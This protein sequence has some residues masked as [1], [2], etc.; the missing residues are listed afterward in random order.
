MKQG[1]VL[2]SLDIVLIAIKLDPT[3]QPVLK[4]KQFQDAMEQRARRQTRS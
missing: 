2:K 3:L 4:W 1:N